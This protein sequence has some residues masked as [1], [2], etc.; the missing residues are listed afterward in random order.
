M[1]ARIIL[2]LIVIGLPFAGRGQYFQYSQYNY[3]DARVN[4]GLVASSDYA[5]AGFIFRNQNTGSSDINMKTSM[6]SL[7]YPFLS[8]K[9]GNRW[10]G[11]GLSLMDDRSGGIF[12][13]Q[14]ASLMYAINVFL[15]RFQSLSLGF[16]ALYQRRSVNV[17][18]LFTGS[19]F[20]HERGF[21]PSLFNGENFGLLASDF[22]T[23]SSGLY[24][25]QQDR[26]E[27]KTAYLGVSFFDFNRPDDSFSGID[28]QLSTTIVG[29]GGINVYRQDNIS[30]M[31]EFLF[32]RSA[33][34]NVLNIGATTSYEVRPYPNQIAGRVD[35]ITRYVPGRS[36][37]VGVQFH[38]EQFSIGFSYDIPIGRR[39]P[40]NTG[41][42]EFALQIRRI[43]DPY[44]KRKVARR[45]PVPTPGQSGEKNLVAEKEIEGA[46]T[47]MR[48]K[49]TNDSDGNEPI[50]DKNLRTS[51]K[52]KADSVMLRA[53]VGP[54]SHEPYIIEKTTLRFGFEFN[55]AKLD[56]AS[57]RYLDD[58]SAAL[59]ENALMKVRLIGHTDNIGSQAFNQR[60]S[61][62]RA[63]V[64]RQYLVDKGVDAG[65]IEAEGKGLSEPLNG[66][67]T[68]AERALN[69]RVEFVIYYK[70]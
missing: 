47:S 27:R 61:K 12:S 22:V 18:G 40:G 44:S 60:L 58:L 51:L 54:V 23:F 38:K 26:M 36:G 41:A 52:Q 32:T 30:L 66:N 28:H 39:N 34:R 2:M 6:L 29:S 57:M 11:V 14:E 20:I 53:R 35:L 68:E 16:K 70:E 67:E 1:K 19:Q 17:N 63:E 50:E 65:R 48:P 25:Q 24:W 3:T 64:I 31:P 56:E 37:I 69:R 15:S 8:R 21:D 7:A 9:N 43:V 55:S 45:K 62:H 33:S 59:R 13:L 49:A 4:P 42:F 46:K 10:S 5:S